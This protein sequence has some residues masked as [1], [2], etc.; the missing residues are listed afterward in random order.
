MLRK[1]RKPFKFSN[2]FEAPVGVTISSHLY[3]THRDENLYPHP[4]V[5]DGFRFVESTGKVDNEQD[6]V[7]GDSGIRKA[8][9][10]TSR[11]YLTFGHGRHAWYVD[12]PIRPFP[13]HSPTRK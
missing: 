11:S 1:V 6:K 10:T 5:F 8:M 7:G 2:G 3:A 9:Y 4:D 12:T 13:D